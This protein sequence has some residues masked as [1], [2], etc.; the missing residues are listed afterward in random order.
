MGW[1]PFKAVVKAVKSVVKAVVN[2]VSDLV[3]AVS[4]TFMSM[5]G[6]PVA[7]RGEGEADKGVRIQLPPATDNKIPVIYGSVFQKGLLVDARIS[8]ANKT[9]TYVLALSEKTQTGTFSVGDI[10]WNDEKLNFSG[11]TVVSSIDSDGNTSTDLN[12]LVRIYV[13]GNGSS[14]PINGGNATPAYNIVPGWDSTWVMSGLVFAVIQMDYNSE[15][16]TTSLPTITFQINN[17]LKN[18]GDVWYDYMTST[19]Y[20]VGVDPEEI[21]TNSSTNTSNPYSLKSF[22]N[23]TL[24]YTNNLGQST[25]G[26]RYEINGILNTGQSVKNNLERILLAA[27]SYM[28]YKHSIGKWVVKLNRAATTSELN[29]AFIFNDDNIISDVSLTATALEQL[30]NSVETEF[31]HRLIKDQ[32][33]YITINVPAELRNDLEPDNQLRLRIDMVNNNIHATRLSN[34][35]LKQT[36]DDLVVSFSSD[37]SGLQC[38][39]GD[40]V[41]ITNSVYGWDNKLFRI[42]RVREIH[43]DDG[44]L[45]ADIT[46]MEYNADVYTDEDITEFDP[47]ANTGIPLFAKITPP[48]APY[49][50][51]QAPVA[52]SPTFTAGLVVPTGVPIDTIELWYSI[53]NGTTYNFYQ[54]RKPANGGTFTAGD[55]VSWV[56]MGAPEEDYYLKARVGVEGRFSDLGPASTIFTWDPNALVSV[57]ALAS[58]FEFFPPTVVVPT[59]SEG[60]NPFTG[61]TFSLRLRSGTTNLDISDATTDAGMANNTWRVSATAYN[62]SHISVSTPT[63][64]TAADTITWTVNDLNIQSAFF[65]V[66]ARYKDS[67]GVVEP[68]GDYMIELSQL[69]SGADGA[70]GK[71]IKLDSNYLTFTRPSGVADNATNQYAPEVITLNARVAN[72]TGTVVFTAIADDL[73]NI[74]LQGSNLTRTLNRTDF[75]NHNY[76]NITASI[77]EGSETYTDNLTIIRVREGTNGNDAVNAV[78]TNENHSIATDSTGAY[79]SLSSATT[80]MKIYLGSNQDTNNWT[81]SITSQTG[82]SGFVVDNITNKGRVSPAVGALLTGDIATI[83]ITASK[84]GYSNVVKTFT[85][86]KSRQGTQGITGASGASAKQVVAN[87]SLPAFIRNQ[88]GV[89]ATAS[90]YAPAS[91]SLTSTAINLTAPIT[92]TWLAQPQGGS[93]TV[94]GGSASLS[95]TRETFITALNANP[96]A[97]YITYTVQAT[98]ATAT[99]YTDSTTVYRVRQGNSALIGYLT[100][101]TMPV[102]ADAT[103]AITGSLSSITS[104]L[105]VYRGVENVSSTVSSYSI[106]SQTGISGASI[107]SSGLITFS[108]SAA[109]TADTGIVKVRATISGNNIDKDFKIVKQLQGITGTTKSLWLDQTSYTITRPRGYFDTDVSQYTPSPI[110]FTANFL[111]WSGSPT[112]TW[113]VD[114][115]VATHDS[116]GLVAGRLN[117][118]GNTATMTNSQFGN[119]NQRSIEVRYTDPSNSVVYIDKGSV[120]RV[121]EG[122]GTATLIASNETMTFAANSAGFL[123]TG[124]YAGQVALTKLQVFVG[125]TEQT[126]S[127]WTI[128]YTYRDTAG[129]TITNPFSPT[130]PTYD[131]NT[132]TFSISPSAI[133]TNRFVIRFT[134]NKTGYPEL[135]KEI[136]IIKVLDG[137]AGING[138]N[139]TNGEN[140]ISIKMTPNALNFIVPKGVADASTGSYTP[141]TITFATLIQNASGQLPIWYIDG[142]QQAVGTNTNLTVAANS[143]SAT[144]SRTQ[145]GNVDSRLVRVGFTYNGTLYYDEQR[146]YRLREGNDGTS[147]TNGTNGTNGVD[148]ITAYLTNEVE[149]VACDVNGNSLTGQ[150][151]K[152]SITALK[153][154]KGTTDITSQYTTF[155]LTNTGCSATQSNGVISVSAITADTATVVIT[156]T[157]TALYPSVSKTFTLV[158]QKAGATGAD[159]RLLS[160]S[161]SSQTFVKLKQYLDSQTSLMI[162]S[163]VVI[164]ANTQ[165][166]PNPVYTWSVSGGGT[167]TGS[168]SSISISNVQF[169]NTDSRTVSLTVSYTGGSISDTLTLFKIREGADGSPG[170]AGTNGVDGVFGYLTNEA[171]SV[172]VDSAG[173]PTSFSGATSQMFI[174]QGTQ[175]ITSLYTINRTAS[176]AT[177]TGTNPITI[178]GLSTNS[179]YVDFVATRSGYSTI[180]RRFSLVKV[181]PGANGTNGTNGLNGA[182]GSN[183]LTAR[184]VYKVQAIADAAPGTPADALGETSIPVGWS[185]TPTAAASLGANQV[186]YVLDG[187][188]NARTTAITSSDG[189]SVQA[190]YTHW[191][192]PAYAASLFLT[193][194]QSDNY[195]NGSSGWKIERA[196]GSAEFNN[197]AVRGLITNGGLNAST[198]NTTNIVSGAILSSYSGYIVGNPAGTLGGT[199]SGNTVSLISNVVIPSGVR[200][201]ILFYDGGTMSAYPSLYAVDYY[202]FPRPTYYF[203]NGVRTLPNA[204]SNIYGYGSEG[205]KHYAVYDPTPGTYEFKITM[206]RYTATGGLFTTLGQHNYQPPIMTWLQIMR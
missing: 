63:I 97:E 85:I 31:P 76:V 23:N 33:D 69:R 194:L 40:V 24:T 129:T 156:T 135:V 53:D 206:S 139:G 95:I 200:L 109:M 100:N 56:V 111:N 114:G 89:D 137:A 201:F 107:N 94:V 203:L 183:G 15:K 191:I 143:L 10:Y 188:Y 121:R 96:G 124:I 112:A 57:S 204:I 29:S 166:L 196:T 167:Y 19:R 43:D 34:I 13:Y 49:I 58:T 78:L 38:D 22:S 44:G 202:Q 132:G 187:I 163:S 17:S 102:S 199:N 16:G 72:I 59:D 83:D 122:D 25:T 106:V 105:Q 12:G 148:A 179:A 3:V 115:N 159:A 66:S 110:T 54:Y 46:A 189:V 87:V 181:Y 152:T 8:N 21:D 84:S 55:V 113:Y 11:N 118:S 6:S 41:K 67:A 88:N 175:D 155:T 170:Q 104:N 161:P 205:M 14:T 1:N 157:A 27:A 98:D 165:N 138:N 26:V 18:P 32:N 160:L 30:Y 20:G 70:D 116:T 71:F 146:I 5:L 9:M 123:N 164:T 149:A 103:G 151:P 92:Y 2:V 62:T 93:Q 150:L 130:I 136:S 37:Y 133:S 173:N 158:K 42:T 90:D 193:D 144:M 140:A 142:V 35:E 190:G 128:A 65:T 75:G 162:P 91:V 197:L 80:D 186:Q 64:D 68:L 108:G 74:T 77:T 99:T 147:G 52:K 172:P 86:V 81:Y 79:S 185:A 45:I 180:T 61:Q 4:S 195:V 178:T 168:G 169:G 174:F 182:N 198:V 171:H 51:S 131:S 101:E 73:T 117:I 134:A 126:I 48:G 82:A 36:R 177:F 127:G 50:I 176:G 192:G 28:T 7:Q 120:A 153:V 184:R 125:S 39:T 145:F 141:A 47:A 154:F 119:V 60:N